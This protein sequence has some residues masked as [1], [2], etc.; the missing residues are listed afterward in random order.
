MI[1]VPDNV[2]VWVLGEVI[3]YDDANDSVIVKLNNNDNREKES[4]FVVK[5]TIVVDSTHLQ[6]LNNLCLLNNLHEAPLLDLLRRRNTKDIIYTNVGKVLISIN[7]YK[8]VHGLYDNPLD[9]F[10][11]NSS[12]C[13]SPNSLLSHQHKNVDTPHVYKI[14]NDAYSALAANLI[15]EG[16]LYDQSIIISGESGSGK[17]EASKYV[18]QFLIQAN[19]FVVEAQSCTQSIAN[20]LNIQTFEFQSLLV[21]SGRI[22][23]SFG[24]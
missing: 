1:W 6:D 20:D 10:M 5:D 7:P 22:F 14:A 16:Y 3:G 13:S 21:E 4:K 23:E 17:T 8:I 19:K 2:D 18:L 11:I 15:S 12:K 24:N 9:Y